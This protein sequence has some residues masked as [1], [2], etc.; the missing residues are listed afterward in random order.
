VGQVAQVVLDLAE[1]L[2]L[3]EIDEA[4]RH[5]AEDLL[6]VGAE[7]LEEGLDAVFAVVGGRGRG[8]SKGV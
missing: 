5:L 8:R 4:L 2:M 7:A 1:G 3:R 6:G